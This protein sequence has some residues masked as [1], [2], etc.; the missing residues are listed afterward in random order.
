[1]SL[2]IN[3]ITFISFTRHRVRNRVKVESGR[4]KILSN[5]KF[6]RESEHERESI[7][8]LCNEKIESESR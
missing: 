4:S 7:T 2:S 5:E 1:M 3:C 6:E 8:R